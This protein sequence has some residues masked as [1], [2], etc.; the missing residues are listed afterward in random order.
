MQFSEANILD[1]K[2]A[3]KIQNSENEGCTGKN[4]PGGASE[5][6][7]RSFEVAKGFSWRFW[8]RYNQMGRENQQNSPCYIQNTSPSKQPVNTLFRSTTNQEAPEIPSQNQDD[9]SGT[10]NQNQVSVDSK[11]G[12]AQVKKPGSEECEIISEN[13]EVCFL[14][15]A[16]WS[17]A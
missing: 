8:A 5:K 17:R 15:C 13:E 3:L 2:Y 11:A 14:M 12:C 10:S 9:V 16:D 6:N 4:L 7:F 1:R